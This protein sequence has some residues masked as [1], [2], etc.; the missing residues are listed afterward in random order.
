MKSVAILQARTNSSRLP[1]KVLLP[2]NEIPLVILAAK[3]AANTGRDVVVATSREAT[4]DYLARLVA[5]HGL[6]CYRGCLENTLDRI[7]SALDNYDDDTLVFRLTADNVFPD[8]GLL[9]EIESDFLERKLDYLCCNGEDSGLPYGVSV[10]LTKLCHL[11][12]AACFAKNKYDLEHV[13]PYVRRQF[14]EAY[15]IKYKGLNSGGYRCTVD[16]FDDYIGVLKAFSE[17][18]DPVRVPVLDLVRRLT[19]TPLQPI[20][21][22]LSKKLVLGTAQLGLNYG[23]VNKVGVPDQ[24]TAT[25]IIKKAIVNGAEFLD[26]A[27]AYGDSEST[28]GT[29]LVSGWSD[30]VRVITKLSPLAD[31]PLDATH[32]VVRAFVESSIYKSCSAL[33]RTSLDVLML[34]RASHLSDWD[35]LVWARLLECKKAG[36][37]NVLGVSIQTPEELA[38][39]LKLPDVEFIQMPLNVLD[40]RW[41]HLVPIIKEEKKKRNLVIHARS[42]LL[43]GLFTSEN[44]EHWTKANVSE[45]GAFIAWLAAQSEFFGRASVVD[46]CLAYVKSLDWVDGVVVGVES[47][48][49]LEENIKILGGVGLSEEEIEQISSSRP[50][51]GENTLNPSIWKS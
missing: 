3:R 18:D 25:A 41:D 23:L 37:V 26:T 27:S 36:M 45:P 16:C 42:A 50:F 17:I 48:S 28:I 4:D 51:V 46:F 11:R 39:A 31:C 6:R 2:I 30:R 44:Y 43:Q 13:T 33:K 20:R 12:S 7:V 9:D 8:G 35:G 22:T 32:A 49:Q 29:A 47:I 15:F 10:E 40:W 1:G 38:I 14:G 24:Q 5:S 19:N 21:S 34:H